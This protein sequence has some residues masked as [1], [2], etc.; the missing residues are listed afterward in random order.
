M[1]ITIGDVTANSSFDFVQSEAATIE[2]AAQS[3]VPTKEVAYKVLDKNG[4]DITS[5]VTVDVQSDKTIFTASKG[6]VI[7]NSGATGSAFAKFVVKND[8]GKVIAES[9]Q[10][11]VTVATAAPTTVAEY[12]TLAASSA[13]L[14]ET[15]YASETTEFKQ[16]NTVN[17]ESAPEYL[18]V[19]VLDQFGNDIA[20]AAPLK[21]ES[22]DTDIA[23][24][25]ATTGKVTPRKAGKAPVRVTL[26]DAN[27]KTIAT[28]TIELTVAAKAE[29]TALEL[30]KEE[31]SLTTTSGVNSTTVTV[32]AIDQF[33]DQFTVGS[34]LETEV[35][36]SKEAV[37][38]ATFDGSTV[39]INA[40]GEGTA[41]LTVT[42]GEI[43][44]EITVSVTEAGEIASYNVTGLK[45]ELLVEDTDSTDEVDETSFSLKVT[46]VD[47]DGLATEVLAFGDDY[48]IEVKDKN[49][50]TVVQN[51]AK[52][53]AADYQD[54]E[55][56]F[57]VT[58]KVG[59]LSVFTGEFKVTDNRVA[60]EYSITDNDLV[61][62]SLGSD[63]DS[64][65]I[66]TA[67]QNLLD[68]DIEEGA[69]VS[70]DA[71]E[72]VS[73]K[74]TVITANN[75]VADGSTQILVD[76]VT[77]TYDKDGVGSDYDEETFELDFGGEIF[78]VLVDSSAPV[79]EVVAPTTLAH[80]AQQLTYTFKATD[81]SNLE[82]LEIDHSLEGSLPE[83]KLYPT[84]NPWG[85]TEGKNQAAGLGV[86]STYDSA[87]KTWT[88]TFADVNEGSSALDAIK[89][90]D[91]SF[92]IYYVVKDIHGN[93]FGSMDPT[94]SDNTVSV[95]VL[96]EPAE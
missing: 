91:G 12:W 53:E 92:D 33:G 71:V 11:K 23:V 67:I 43:S 39:T 70:V 14:D 24:V 77:I 7:V 50:D 78:N 21:Y 49:G 28:K 15:T 69:S 62:T 81:A 75:V 19:S 93:T 46:G 10:V 88:L 45:S 94:T 57:T 37:A 8:A 55:G 84:E 5:T 34:G 48:T 79:V 95:D 89:A 61:F 74:E 1:A 63:D 59:S 83:F 56:P 3:V 87:T 68:F 60:P 42:V 64:D 65:A 47:A 36:S 96:A 58:V 80:D 82:F 76:T 44:K 72:F 35:V 40:I 9:A 22:L 73:K 16:D 52:F 13:V 32:K 54:E 18:N 41:T 51:A 17:L 25:D 29:L 20:P 26:S 38:T 30:S 86:S 4:L 2:L 31:V 6:K 27:G 66:N 90:V 85:T